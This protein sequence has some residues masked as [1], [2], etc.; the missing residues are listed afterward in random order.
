MLA[1]AKSYIKRYLGLVCKVRLQIS[2]SQDEIL[3][4]G[5]QSIDLIVLN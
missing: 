1:I 5:K 2:K 4:L 3:I